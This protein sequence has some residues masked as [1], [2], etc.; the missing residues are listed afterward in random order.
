MP[1]HICSITTISLLTEALLLRCQSHRVIFLDS[2]FIS[3]KPVGGIK[4]ATCGIKSPILFF[5]STIHQSEITQ[6]HLAI[7]YKGIGFSMLNPY[8]SFL[9]YSPEVM[10]LCYFGWANDVKHISPSTNPLNE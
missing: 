7:I 4:P 1:L 8:N 6:R 3:K 9:S 5:W 10:S 2:L